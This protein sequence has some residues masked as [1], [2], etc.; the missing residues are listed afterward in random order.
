MLAAQPL[1]DEIAAARAADTG[2]GARIQAQV[3][4]AMAAFDAA[5]AREIDERAARRM[6]EHMVAEAKARA[7]RRS[8]ER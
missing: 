4:R 6:E 8:F 5:R 3:D 7:W 2:Y 1:R